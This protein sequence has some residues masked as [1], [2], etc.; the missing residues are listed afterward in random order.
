MTNANGRVVSGPRATSAWQIFG[1]SFAIYFATALTW[2][3][4]TPMFGVPDEISHMIRAAAASRGDI[5]GRMLRDGN[6]AYEAPRILVPGSNNGS[7]RQPCYAFDRQLSPSCVTY[8][9]GAGDV[10]IVSTASA[11]PA[12]YYLLVGWPSR[13]DGGLRGLY[14][15]RAANALVFAALLA[16][17]TVSFARERVRPVAYAGLA[18]AVTP[19]VW[20]LGGSVNPSAS[21]VAAAIAAWCGGYVLVAGRQ[22]V[23]R[24][25]ATRFGLPLCLLLLLRRDSILWGGI[26]VLGLGILVSRARLIELARSRPVLAWAAASFASAFFAASVGASQGPGVLNAAGLEGSAPAAF[27]R[28][29]TYLE[30][31]VGVLGWLDTPLPRSAYLLWYLCLGLLL[32]RTIGEARPRMVAAV[33][34]VMLAVGS[35]IV[36]IGANVYPYFQGRYGLP[37]AVGVPLLAALGLATSGGGRSGVG[38]RPATIVIATSLIVQVLAFYQQLRRYALPGSEA[39]WIFGST[40]WRPPTAPI[41]LLLALNVACAAALAIWWS[42]G[43]RHTLALSVPDDPQREKL[44]EHVGPPDDASDA[45]RLDLR[46]PGGPREAPRV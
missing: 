38:R 10:R 29:L 46:R 35:A 39:L 30:E 15:M 5:D 3:A 43:F 1:V 33:V 21:S 6:V 45:G 25:T 31:M 32:L 23:N 13:L 20:F 18:V 24:V 16:L 34:S 7:V 19:M 36:A 27:G 2:A 28:L 44:D 9:R 22:A 17:A 14:L 4:A 37:A 12:S 40:V 11:Y 41:S 8:G 42:A 26:L